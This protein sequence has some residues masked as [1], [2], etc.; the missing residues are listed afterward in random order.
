MRKARAPAL[1]GDRV[2]A[3]IKILDEWSGKLTWELLIKAVEEAT[4]ITY[5]R[6]T[7][8]DREQIADAFALRKRLSPATATTTPRDERVRAALEQVE[9]YRMK[10]ARL[11]Q[12]NQALLEQFV[13]WAT[14]AERKGVTMSMLNAPLP[15]PQRDRTKGET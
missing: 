15:K 6:F 2:E 5:S 14:N 7:L 8:M 13:I 4:G 9:R 12:E 10:V 11:E 1:T 3:T